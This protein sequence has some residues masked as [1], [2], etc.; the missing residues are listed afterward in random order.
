MKK[1]KVG[2]VLMVT[3][4]VLVLLI[5]CGFAY[6]YFNGLSGVSQTSEAKEGQIKVACVGDSITYG[7]GISNWPKNN[8]P[9]LL[10]GLLGDG[11]HVQSFGVSG[12]CVQD[13]SDQPYRALEHY[14]N[15][16]A[17]EADILV[18]MMGTNDSK[19]EN[20]Q[21]EEAFKSAVEELLDSY[22]SGEKKPLVYLCTPAT[23]FFTEGFTGD[24]TN[25]D[26]QP[27]IVNVIDG[28]MRQIAEE[29]GYPIIDIHTLTAENPQWFAKDGVH[30]NN[31][32]A[33]AI[34]EKIYT[35]LSA[36]G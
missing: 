27:E 30:P 24:L 22:L 20:W 10:G 16:L 32:G 23:A 21:G 15:S 7:H 34:A 14:Q 11:Y 33:A 2:K 28:I 8:Y 12:R 29:R 35:E 9:K 31:E 3:V 36:N 13:H 25:Y 18:F 6:L 5:I 17:Y 4:L 26:I 19:P 1:K